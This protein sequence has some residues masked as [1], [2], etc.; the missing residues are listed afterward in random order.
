MDIQLG[1]H[2][3]HIRTYFRTATNRERH[4][5]SGQAETQ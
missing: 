3:N 2:T 5:G 1:K 4:L